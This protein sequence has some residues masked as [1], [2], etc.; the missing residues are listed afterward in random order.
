MKSCHF[1]VEHKMNFRISL[2]QCTKVLQWAARGAYHIFH[3]QINVI[4]LRDLVKDI[5]VVKIMRKSGVGSPP[6]PQV[7]DHLLCA[8]AFRERTVLFKLLIS[9][10]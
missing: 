8:N 4:V 5:I 1:G 9:S 6:V 3:A 2:S 7:K 10:A